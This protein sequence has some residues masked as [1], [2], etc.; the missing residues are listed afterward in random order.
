MKKSRYTEEQIMGILKESKAEPSMV[1]R[2]ES[3][4]SC[5]VRQ[6]GWFCDL[7]PSALAEYDAMSTHFQVPTGSTLFMEGEEPR[8]ISIVCIGRVKL[9]RTSRNGKTLLVR[10]AKPGDVLGLSAALAQTA[11]EVAAE[12]LEYTQMKTFRREDFLQFLKHHIEAS[13]KAANSLNIEYRAALSDASR[14]ALL[15]TVN[16]RLAHLLIELALEAGT[17]EDQQPIIHIPF[18]QADIAAMIGCSRESVSRA[19]HAFRS[20]GV[21]AIKGSSVTLRRKYVLES[22]L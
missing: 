22:M 14:L 8:G 21:L 18:K 12:A 11:Y 9:T 1:G 17:L 6:P 15:D 16:E 5:N 13:Q 20:K 19:L 7:P 4:V 2:A 10:I 3:C